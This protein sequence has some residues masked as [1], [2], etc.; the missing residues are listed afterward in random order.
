MSKTN[1][2]SGFK[3]TGIYP[4]DRYVVAC[5]PSGNSEVGIQ[6]SSSIQYLPL[7]TLA[8]CEVLQ[9]MEDDGDTGIMISPSF[10]SP[11]FYRPSREK[12]EEEK[13]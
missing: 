6:L 1:I 4:V 2:K 9:Y 5:K 12:K 8:R 13:L 3:T 11:V 10:Q 7:F